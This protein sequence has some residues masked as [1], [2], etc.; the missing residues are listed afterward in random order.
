MVLVDS[1]YY[2]AS[3]GKKVYSVW[4]TFFFF[5]SSFLL[6]IFF[7]FLHNA[8]HSVGIVNSTQ[9]NP[10]E[11]EVAHKEHTSK[12]RMRY[13]PY[14]TKNSQQ[15]MI[16]YQL[17][18]KKAYLVLRT[19]KS[20]RNFV[21]PPCPTKKSNGKQ[22]SSNVVCVYLVYG[23]VLLDVK[24]TKRNFTVTFQEKG[25]RPP[26]SASQDLGMAS[27]KTV[28]HFAVTPFFKQR[29]QCRKC[30]VSPVFAMAS[31]CDG[32]LPPKF[33]FKQPF[34]HKRRTDSAFMNLPKIVVYDVT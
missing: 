23:K 18:K 30:S 29:M 7:F 6:S 3:Y 27:L 12:Q 33:R 26:V 5:L 8:V 2:T 1:D 32:R 10:T 21:K 19:T 16:F 15:R 25:A 20:S 28:H 22:S 34:K 17:N 9:L 24:P 13:T 14:T 11:L 31:R 4:C